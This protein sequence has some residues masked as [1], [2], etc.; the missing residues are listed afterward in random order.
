MSYAL[1]AAPTMSAAS[2][3]QPECQR[4]PAPLDC[5]TCPAGQ[6][7]M[8]SAVPG[9]PT[10]GTMPSEAIP[11]PVPSSAQALTWTVMKWRSW[12]MDP[13]TWGGVALGAVAGGLGARSARG[14]VGGAWV[15]AGATMFLHANIPG[16]SPVPLIAAGSLLT[17]GG[18][19][20]TGLFGRR[21]VSKNTRR[22]RT[23]RRR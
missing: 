1:G 13:G 20:L 2:K 21:S 22:R 11:P 7:V 19:Y 23:S 3:A 15:G 10:C 14:A 18:T 8:P 6:A 9:V 16:S 4:I 12:A 5:Y 17:L